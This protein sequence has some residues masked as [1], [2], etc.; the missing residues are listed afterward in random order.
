MEHY[1]D[2]FRG[3]EFTPEAIKGYQEDWKRLFYEREL[4]TLE[5]DKEKLD[6][7]PQKYAR[8]Y[9]KEVFLKFFKATRDIEDCNSDHQ[10]I[11]ELFRDCFP[12]C[13]TRHPNLDSFIDLGCGAGWPVAIASMLRYRAVGI[14]RNLEVLT[15]GKEI[16]S[17]LKIGDERLMG[18]DYLQDTFWKSNHCGVNPVAQ[19]LFLLYQPKKQIDMGLPFVSKNMHENSRIITGSDFFSSDDSEAMDQELDQ[20]NLQIET[21]LFGRYL[22]LK[23]K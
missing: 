5:E 23:K 9:F 13:Y 8:D 10:N 7:D 19:T 22:I 2:S 16:F 14:E 3:A 18:G 12:Y 11:G 21:N 17:E 15:L 4:V 20:F 6:K 1:F